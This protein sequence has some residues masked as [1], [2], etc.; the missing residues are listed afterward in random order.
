M[1]VFAVSILFIVGTLF[2]YGTVSAN[3]SGQC[4]GFNS[5]ANTKIDTND[6]SVILAAGTVF[7]IHASNNN[8]GILVA[9][10]TTTLDEYIA[11]NIINHGGQIP[12]ISNYVIYP[13]VPTPT[14]TPTPAITPT[15]TPNVT[16]TPTPNVTPTPIVTPTPTI[17]PSPSPTPSPTPVVTPNAN[18]TPPPTNTIEGSNT[19]SGNDWLTISLIFG[20]LVVLFS[21]AGLGRKNKSE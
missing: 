11:A 9:D 18:V 12:A 17:S 15:P 14:I 2:A 13:A 1:K 4:P 5:P 3:Q 21:V 16:P 20:G 8:T 7:C 19:V 10:G 6:G